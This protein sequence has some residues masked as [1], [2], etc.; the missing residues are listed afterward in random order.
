MT[1]VPVQKTAVQVDYCRNF[2]RVL[3][4]Q[5]T[6]CLFSLKIRV[7][8]LFTITAQFYDCISSKQQTW[9]YFWFCFFNACTVNR[10]HTIFSGYWEL[11]CMQPI[12]RNPWTPQSINVHRKWVYYLGITCNKFSNLH[13][14]WCSVHCS[15][16]CR[17]LSWQW[18][19]M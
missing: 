7:M 1:Y 5:M 9:T 4:M 19:S 8:P 13:R 15:D 3:H 16:F 18:N 17:E 14:R 10:A 6:A 2:C 11:T 12:S